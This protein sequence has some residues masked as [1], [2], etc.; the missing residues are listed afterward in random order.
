MRCPGCNCAATGV[1]DS[2]K[3]E[4]NGMPT[5]WRRRKCKSCGEVFETFEFAA[6]YMEQPEET[7]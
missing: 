7:E 5:V 4:S 3:V 1:I 2:R 6:A